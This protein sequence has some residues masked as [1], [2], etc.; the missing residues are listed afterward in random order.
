LPGPVAEQ[1]SEYLVTDD[2]DRKTIEGVYAA[3]FG[4]PKKFIQDLK[5]GVPGARVIE[6]PGANHYVFL[7]NEADVLREIR[8]FL[9]VR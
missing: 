7:S 1:L 6:L 2:Q 4:Y 9:E 5:S 8:A 3:D